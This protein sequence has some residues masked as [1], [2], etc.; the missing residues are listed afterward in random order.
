MYKV[1][2]QFADLTDNKYL[3]RAGDTFPRNGVSV[4]D[5]RLQELASANNKAGKPLIKEV[6][7]KK[8]KPIDTEKAVSDKP[9][10]RKKN[11]VN[12]TL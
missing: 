1:I 12:D 9:K 5:E 8:P 7:E 6:V 10:R 3:Y 4:S 11:D 2:S